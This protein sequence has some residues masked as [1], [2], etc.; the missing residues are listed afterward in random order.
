M[1]AIDSEVAVEFCKA[2][3]KSR[4]DLEDIKKIRRIG[5]GI[6]GG[7]FPAYELETLFEVLGQR[8]QDGTAVLLYAHAY[9]NLRCWASCGSNGSAGLSTSK[10]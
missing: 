7:E 1:Y 3:G 2:A 6:S 9:N 10:K 5:L 4:R 8:Y